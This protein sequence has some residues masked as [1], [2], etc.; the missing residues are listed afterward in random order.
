MMS[1]DDKVSLTTDEDHQDEDNIKQDGEPS[2]QQEHGDG[3]AMG[4]FWDGVTEL[5][6]TYRN[7]N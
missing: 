1:S 7:H 6:W 2:T 4:Q 3:T 5:M